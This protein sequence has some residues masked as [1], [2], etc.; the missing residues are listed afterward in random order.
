MIAVD[1]DKG[2][3]HAQ[4]EISEELMT[5]VIVLLLAENETHWKRQQPPLHSAYILLYLIAM[6]AVIMTKV[7]EWSI[8][9]QDSI[10]REKRSYMGPAYDSWLWCPADSSG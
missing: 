5:V 7:L 6:T 2:Y 8:V 1:G 3:I 10:V 4:A 9:M